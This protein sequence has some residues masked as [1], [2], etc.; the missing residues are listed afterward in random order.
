MPAEESLFSI[1]FSINNRITYRA[2][3]MLLPAL[4]QCVIV[5]GNAIHIGSIK[6]V[7]DDLTGKLFK[8]MKISAII[9]NG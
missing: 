5:A 7:R 9:K 4:R 6:N 8:F 3:G 1:C 2:Q